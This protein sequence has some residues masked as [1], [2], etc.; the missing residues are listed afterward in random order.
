MPHT[1]SYKFG[2]IV[3]VPF[4]FTDQTATK[5]RPAVVI[6]SMAYHHERPDIILMAVTSQLRPSTTVGEAA[7]HFWREAGL[8]KPSVIKPI[9]T[10]VEEKRIIKKLGQRSEDDEKVLEGVISTILGK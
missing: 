9:L 4:P 2:D 8:I 10:T 1:T 7:I 5:L 6:S 3:L